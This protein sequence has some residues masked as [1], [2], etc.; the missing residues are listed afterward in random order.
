MTT[1]WFLISLARLRLVFHGQFP[2]F[3][4]YSNAQLEDYVYFVL[5]LSNPRSPPQRPSTSF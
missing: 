2:D 1:L 4:S 3:L 5:R